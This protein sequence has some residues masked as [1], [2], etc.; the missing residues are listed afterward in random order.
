MSMF[1]AS[2]PKSAGKVMVPHGPD[3]EN[4]V[5]NTLDDIAKMVGQ[6]LGPGGRQ[7]LIERPEINM[8]PIVTKDGVTVIKHLGYDSATRQLILEAARDAA[9]RTATEAGDG[10]TTATILS[11]SIAQYTSAVVKA[12]PK[13]SPQKIVR[14]MQALMPTISEIISKYK[15]DANDEEV[16]YQVARLSSNG[17]EALA[18]KIIEAMNLV[19]DEGELTIIE[20]S[21][22]TSITVDRINGYWIEKGYEESCRNLANGFINDKSG[23]MVVMDQP[24]FLLYDGFVTDTMQVLNGLNKLAA[25]FESF[26]K[27]SGRKKNIVLCA[28]GFAEQVLGDFH[29]NWNDHRSTI[30]VYP[31]LTP[32]T[33]VHNSRT[34]FLYDIQA[35][36]GV[37]VFNPVDKPIDDIDVAS[38]EKNCRATYFESSRF[39]SSVQAKED[40][41][42]I[43]IRVEELKEALKKPE[44]QYDALDLQTRIGKLTSG[45][46]RL[47]VAGPS[48]AETREKRD[49][50]ED[51]WMAI[52]GAIK[53]GACPGGGY[54]LTRISAEL[55]SMTKAA[56]SE[57]QRYS[58]IILAEALQR[59]VEVLYRNYGHTDEE[60]KAQVAALL[61]DDSVTYDVAEGKWVAKDKLLDSL[62]AVSEAIRNSISIASLLGTLGGI[63][64]FKRDRDE[65][66]KEADFI[67][68]FEA[69]IGERG[70]VAQTQSG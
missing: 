47:T 38:I 24:I 5:I 36:V 16:L 7:V 6:T 52:R 44:S 70:S 29:I 60:I 1:Q 19:G 53:H 28:H 2:K 11:A 51:A 35:Y 46:A 41:A 25:H 12:N 13:M 65:D 10:T 67:R 30:A 20:T 15:I 37:P 66:A 23:T 50:A 58:M 43:D 9:T 55:I 40:P 69:A 21:G 33:A 64:S 31:L 34:N 48:S 27:S 56:K 61:R 3:L 49:R 4:L 14:E 42:A 26:K 17:D 57:A 68:R 62:P 22:N 63:V 18:R 54:V 45:I 39:K 32:E 8:K 59:P